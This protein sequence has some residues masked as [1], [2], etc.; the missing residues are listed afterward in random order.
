MKIERKSNA[1][2]KRNSL[3]SSVTVASY[4]YYNYYYYYYYYYYYN[5]YY[6]YY[7]YN[8]RTRSSHWRSKRLDPL[9]S[10][11]GN[12]FKSIDAASQPSA[13]TTVKL[14]SC[15]SASPSLCSGS[16]L[17]RSRTHLRKLLSWSQFP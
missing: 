15:S 4:Y 10:K 13:T 9:T 7:Y 17:S 16:T 5:Y 8:K 14:H 1:S 3:V 12:F 2:G 6:Y 11:G